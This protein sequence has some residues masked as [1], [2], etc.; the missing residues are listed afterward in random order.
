MSDSTLAYAKMATTS[1]INNMHFNIGREGKEMAESPI[2]PPTL[3]QSYPRL[4]QPSHPTAGSRGPDLDRWKS[5][6]PKAG[7]S[8][9]VPKPLFTSEKCVVDIEPAATAA[10]SEIPASISTIG[11]EVVSTSPTSAAA[12]TMANLT[13]ISPT[14]SLFPVPPSANGIVASPVTMTSPVSLHASNSVVS[15]SS[16][17]SQG[18]IGNPTAAAARPRP[19]SSIYSQN[20]LTTLT[21]TAASSPRTPTLTDWSSTLPGLPSLG[22]PLANSNP[23]PHAP[24]HMEQVAEEQPVGEQLIQAQIQVPRLRSPSLPQDR[25]NRKRT[26][27]YTGGVSTPVRDSGV[28]M[29]RP[30]VSSPEHLSYPEMSTVP[31]DYEGNDWPLQKPSVVHDV[32]RKHYV[33]RSQGSDVSRSE[34]YA[35]H[36]ANKESISSS[37]GRPGHL[38]PEVASP[39]V[40]MAESHTPIFGPGEQRSGWWSDEEDVEQGRGRISGYAVIGL[41]E[42]PTTEAQRRRVRKVK[43][44]VGASILA[45]LIIVGIAV[46]VALGVRK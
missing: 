24:V 2:L 18:T 23:Q 34:P 45:I 33:S 28:I 4:Q 1:T 42:K 8:A 26:L 39:R 22:M 27:S 38:E 46:G 9:L 19:V 13:P 21:V 16:V 43:I 15:R 5:R 41:K 32:P 40:S 29:N 12:M 44:I 35:H 36:V 3:A 20:T 25:A 10:T 6:V 37:S 14:P 17:Y 31:M 7:N 11:A 30:M